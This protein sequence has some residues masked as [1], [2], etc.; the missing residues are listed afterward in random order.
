MSWQI[1]II[2]GVL[3]IIGALVFALVK[4]A[5]RSGRMEERQT[6][7]N[8]VHMIGKEIDETI[9]NMDA[10]DHLAIVSRLRGRKARRVQREG[11]PDSA[12]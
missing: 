7:I 6:A 4:V 1:G 12:G 2:A 8:A 9:H 11:K 3:I 10:D 5:K